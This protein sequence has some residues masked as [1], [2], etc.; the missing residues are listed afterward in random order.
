[1]STRKG[2]EVNALAVSGYLTLWQASFQAK[3]RR[4]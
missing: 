2:Y 3:K 1:M 4:P